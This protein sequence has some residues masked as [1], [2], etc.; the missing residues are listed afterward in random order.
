[1]EVRTRK[2]TGELVSADKCLI[3]PQSHL[4]PHLR[5]IQKDILCPVGAIRPVAPTAEVV[6]WKGIL[7]VDPRPPPT[8]PQLASNITLV[9]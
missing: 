7:V 2:F 8:P 4:Q 5:W 3:T 6:V 1:M 9:Q